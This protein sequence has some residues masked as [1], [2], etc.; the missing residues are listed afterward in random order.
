MSVDR[1]TMLG[2]GSFK[3]IS[4][5]HFRRDDA[6]HSRSP[7]IVESARLAPLVIGDQRAPISIELVLVGL[8]RLFYLCQ[9]AVPRPP[10]ALVSPSERRDRVST[11]TP[12]CW[13]RPASLVSGRSRGWW[14]CGRCVVAC[15]LTS[16]VH[17]GSRNGNRRSAG[18][19]NGG[20]CG[21]RNAGRG[22]GET[23]VVEGGLAQSVGVLTG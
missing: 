4:R 2:R 5:T 20:W 23:G 17:R 12:R 9:L 15:E 18:K 10:T 11:A 6:S 3:A 8:A 7:V 1:R 19:P 21:L 22:C 16:E 13:A 14:G